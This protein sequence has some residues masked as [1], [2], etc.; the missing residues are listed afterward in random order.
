MPNYAVHKIQKYSS[1][2]SKC[3][4]NRP[5]YAST[6]WKDV[7]CKSCNKFRPDNEIP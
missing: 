6:S 4:V 1:K 3:E 5:S 7:T 2:V